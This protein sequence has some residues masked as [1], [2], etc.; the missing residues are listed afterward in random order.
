M[1][2]PPRHPWE[3]SWVHIFP[4]SADCLPT[5][6]SKKQ[7]EWYNSNGNYRSS[8]EPCGQF[9]NFW[10]IKIGQIVL[11]YHSCKDSVRQSKMLGREL[12]VY[13]A[14][15]ACCFLPPF[16]FPPFLLGY[17]ELILNILMSLVWVPRAA[18]SVIKESWGPAPLPLPPLAL[19]GLILSVS[20]WT[21][22]SNVGCL[23]PSLVC[24]RAR[25]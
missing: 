15:H 5:V 14:I 19:Q 13:V 25:R 17:A 9:L 12:G 11:S 23:F 3:I 18:I 24:M 16:H 21:C 6:Y 4:S 8:M 2:E 10:M 1:A 7:V 20:L 22:V